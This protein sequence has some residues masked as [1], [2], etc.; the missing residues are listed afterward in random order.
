LRDRGEGI[1]VIELGVQSGARAVEER[2]DT[3]QR[4]EIVVD[5]EGD[6]AVLKLFV[7]HDGRAQAVEVDALEVLKEV[8]EEGAHIEQLERVA[9]AQ[10]A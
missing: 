5:L 2:E 8:H 9:H 6:V 7:V 10:N 1:D 4:Q 3:Y